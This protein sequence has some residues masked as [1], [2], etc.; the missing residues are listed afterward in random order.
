MLQADVY[1]QN[2]EKTGDIALPES[3]FGAEQNEAAVYYSV[4]AYLTNQRQGNACTKERGDIKASTRKPWRQKGT[5]RARSG[6]VSSPV[7]RGGGTVFGP[8]PKDF[9]VRVPKKIRRLAF[10]SALSARAAEEKAVIA[11]ED[12]SFDTPKTK[13]V[14][15]LLAKIESNGARVLIMLS[16]HKPLVWKSARNIQR[17]EVKPFT[18]CNA[19]DVLKADKIVIEKSVIEQMTSETK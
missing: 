2:G 8:Q 15:D 13:M 11:V 16:E 10:V 7:W 12:L 1:N 19:Y 4:N 6:M 9:D 14:T 3:F 17:L 18:E 5:G